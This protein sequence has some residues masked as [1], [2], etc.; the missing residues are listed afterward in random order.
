MRIYGDFDKYVAGRKGISELSA[1]LQN[2]AFLN[3]RYIR[4]MKY[5]DCQF[6][7]TEMANIAGFATAA[8]LSGWDTVCEYQ[9]YK[10]S[11]LDGRQNA[12]GR[13]DL[14]MVNSSKHFYCEAKFAGSLPTNFIRQSS[15]WMSRA[16]SDTQKTCNVRRGENEE[17][18]AILF[19]ALYSKIGE[20]EIN[21]VANFK[22]NLLESAKTLELQA[23][24]Y[25]FPKHSIKN[26]ADRKNL[27]GLATLIKTVN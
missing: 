14:Y 7:Y 11:K 19:V 8:S 22:S 12:P 1:V 24:S 9:Q 6:G 10:K 16:V 21:A 25:Y 23:Y 15:F 18:L 13:V 5:Q 2:H 3:D 27:I 20:S 26:W 4:T 17:G